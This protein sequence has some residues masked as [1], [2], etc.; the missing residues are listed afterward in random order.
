ME[1]CGYSQNIL[2]WSLIQGHIL[3]GNGK[4]SSVTSQGVDFEESDL[5]HYLL[6]NRKTKSTFKKW[7][8]DNAKSYA[9]V[10]CWNRP[11]FSGGWMESTF[12]DTAAYNLQTPSIFVD[13]RFPTTRPTESL[14]KRQLC[15]GDCSDLEL[16]I[17]ARQHCFA[18]YSLPE[19][20]DDHSPLT[21]TRHHAIDWNYHPRFPRNRP[22]RWWI[23]LSTDEKSFKEYSFARDSNNV[24]VYFER[25]ARVDGDSQG[26]KYMALRKKTPCPFK[27]IAEGKQPQR[28]SILVVVGNYFAIVTDRQQPVPMLEEYSGSMGGMA[29]LVDFALTSSSTVPERQL[30]L[31]KQAEQLLDITG[32]FGRI[33]HNNSFGDGKAQ[34]NIEKS[35]MPWLEG[36]PLF[37]RNSIHL[38][39][40]TDI[41]IT[42]TSGSNNNTLD[43]PLHSIM[44]NDEE[45][46][47]L[48]CSFTTH[49]IK[50]MF[51]LC[52][53]TSR[54]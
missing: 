36:R 12:A 52:S 51:A 9:I 18:G 35:T 33:F 1:D 41:D 17:L 15:L 50:K 30:T 27:M 5:P 39:W 14:N 11:L 28:D 29:A 21:F 24:P 22:N 54:L 46:E 16:R 45:W 37:P 3:T 34:W 49:E 26:E 38:R 43:I 20:F 48:E 23:E 4:L 47:V 44:C 32:S 7:L 40:N 6:T 10:G 31:R 42:T 2:N 13:L 8:E 19:T 25:W 53:I